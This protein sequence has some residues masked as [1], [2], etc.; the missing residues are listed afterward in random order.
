LAF[1][2]SED[3]FRTIQELREN[4]YELAR[5]LLEADVLCSVAHPL[6]RVNNR[7]TVEHVEKLLLLFSRFEAINGARD[8]RAAAVVDA[9]FRNLTPELIRR[10]ADRH[11]IEPLGPQPWKKS[12]TAGSDDHSGVYAASAYTVTPHA[13]NVDEFLAHLR[14]GDHWPEGHSGGSV[15]LGHGLYH[16]AYG[17]YRDRFARDGDG[18][19]TLIGELFR[20]LLDETRRQPA[21]GIGGRIRGLATR[22]FWARKKSRLSEV[23]RELVEE[24]SQLFSSEAGPDAASAPVDDRR[25]FH[26][27]C[28]I[29]HALGYSFLRRFEKYAREGRLIESLQTVASLGPVALSMAPYLAAFSAQHKDDGFLHGVAER[30]PAAAHLQQRSRCKAW[31][32]D[33]FAEVNGVTRTIRTLAGTARETGR[34]LTVITCLDELPETSVDLKNFVPVGTFPLPEYESQLISFPPFLQILEYIERRQFNELIIS[35]PGP[36]GLCALAAARLLGLPTKGIYHTDF[37]RFIHHVTDDHDLEALVWRYMLWF[38]ENTDV[39]LVPSEDYR[40]Q[41]LHHGFTPA[42]LA[43]LRRGVDTG[44]FNPGKRDEDFYR[45]YGLDGG[46]KLIYVGRVS[47]E[48]NLPS[49][50][51]AMR[52]LHQRGRR[53]SL[54]VVG[55]GPYLGEMKRR[56]DGLP[57]CFTG[58][59]EGERLA[60]AYASADVMVFPSTSD[61][62]GNAVLEAQASGLPAIVS[63]RGGPQEIVRAHAS[64]IVVDVSQPGSLA[65]AMD[66]L[67]VDGRLRAEMRRRALRTAAERSWEQVLEELYGGE[68]DVLPTVRPAGRGR[69]KCDS[70]NDCLAA[71]VA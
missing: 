43:V 38:Y 32:T 21:P 41:L 71:D 17:Y 34:E 8:G 3:E 46:A 4:I 44:L 31:I 62:F 36:M 19:P 24:F 14:R 28:R 16:I 25:T 27:A 56:C 68:A 33:T 49:L 45:P 55:D 54:A 65:E 20:K 13:E 18:K 9:V 29:S 40:R 10:M 35:T 30:F 52:T 22:F 61:T 6:Y 42:K 12:F 69:A 64:G 48:K 59:L 47:Q 67:V 58:F 70:Q 39:I 60:A 2:I 15:M 53:A 26:I 23:E 1:G 51:D 50:V 57:V 66:R 5:Y 7:L 11:G 63:D 37:P